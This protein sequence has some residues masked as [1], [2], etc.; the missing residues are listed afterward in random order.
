M[1]L[2]AQWLR[3]FVEIPVDDARLADDLTHAGIAVETA[4]GS[5]DGPILDIVFDMD[6]TTN[7]P[8]AMNHY[9]AAREASALYDLPLKPIVPKLPTA[10]PGTGFPIEI[11]EPDLCPRF[12]ARVVRNVVIRPSP[13]PITKR[14][15]LL[16]HRGISNVVDASNYVLWEIGKP[17]HAFDLDLLEGGK[18]V[19]RKACAGETLKTLDGIERKLTNEDLIVADGRKPIALAGV[20]GGFDTMITDKTKNI[21]IESAWF[22][23]ATVRAMS[24][25][26]GLHTDASHRFERGADFEST[27]LSCNRVA[28][29]VLASGVGEPNGELEGDIIDIIARP[30]PRTSVILHLAEVRRHLGK[31][32]TYDEVCRILQRLGFTLTPATADENAEL[33]V[34]IPSWRLDVTREIDLIEEIARQHGYNKFPNTLP[35]FSGSVTELPNAPK[36]ARLRTSL[37]ALGYN[38]AISMTFI[39]PEHAKTFSAADVL[40]VANPLSDEASAMRTSLI[41]GMLDMLAWNLNRG[42]DNVRLF[43]SGNIFEKTATSRDE[44]KRICMG[45][46]GNAIPTSVHEKSRPYSFFDVK[47]DIEALLSAFLNS[48]AFDTGAAPYF[49]PGRSARAIIGGKQVAQFGQIHPDIAAVRKFRQDVF[50]AEIYLDKLYE[51]K[52][53]EPRYSTPSKFPAVARDFSFVFPETTAFED[54]RIVVRG[55]PIPLLA[56][57]DPVETFRGGNTAAGKYSLL[58]RAIFQSPDRTLREEELALWSTQIMQSLVN[59]GGALRT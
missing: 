7:R 8:D 9:G 10:K 33:P 19:I 41:P 16:D 51:E 38:E 15:A 26:H 42:S 37:L 57:F 5:W 23:P 50:V 55:L 22:D 3:E 30:L 2:S 46:T 40:M 56:A 32:L 21:L 53:R 13:A 11:Q 39:A 44:Q 4:T 45:A 47:G 24:R 34:T 6:I 48:V 27:I 31:E 36:D 43:E 20:M 1:K 12:T 25:R 17:T 14:L 54:I 59:L 29:L 58:L 18:I 49:H 28:E 35:P 52:L